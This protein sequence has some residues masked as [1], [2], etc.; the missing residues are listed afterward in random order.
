MIVKDDLGRLV[1][2]ADAKNGAARRIVTLTPAATENLFAIGA[3]ARVVG[4]TAMDDFPPAVKNLP[5]IGSNF[6]QPSVERVRALA[7]DL[8]LVDSAT[9]N[10]AA[11]TTLEGRL[12][13]PLF[14]QVSDGFDDV[15][16]HL[17][18]LGRITGRDAAARRVAAG[19]RQKAARVEKSVRG[20]P[21]VRV[22]VE[23]SASPLF[24]AG[25]GSFVDDLITRAGGVNVV[26]GTVP[27]PQFSREAL[28]AAD[29]DHYIVA[30]GA[31]ETGRPT[32]PPPLDRLRAA[33]QGNV[34]R[35]PADLLFRPT[36]RLADGLVLMARA[37][38]GG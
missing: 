23:I 11:V 32:L 5:R 13:A 19:V 30:G 38:H 16:R 10:R 35:I 28:L 29:P 9:I 37:L 6:T 4:V 33:R 2:V 21:K 24:A 34:H 7:P 22:F 27:Y 18:Q 15:E 8:V 14:I 3:G 17:L 26:K 36:P 31:N 20:K 1:T 12:R 25:P